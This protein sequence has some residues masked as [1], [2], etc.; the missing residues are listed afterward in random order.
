MGERLQHA[1]S[2]LRSPLGFRVVVLVLAA[3]LVL[4]VAFVPEV[5]RSERSLLT[6]LFELGPWTPVFL[7]LAYSLSAAL[8][9]PAF[10]LDL[11]AGA[12]FDFVLGVFWVQ[13]AA[14]LAAIPGYFIGGR[15]LRRFFDRILEQKPE[16]ARV[17][18]ALAQEGGRIVFLA[19]LSPVFSFSLLSAFFG[20]VG[21]PFRS[22][23]LATSVGILPGTAM[24]VYA[25]AMAGD[26]S[27]SPGNPPRS[28]GQWALDA[29][30]FVATAALVV[31]VTRRAQ[32]VLRKKLDEAESAAPRS[33]A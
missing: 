24:Y 28:S 18:R 7:I 6:R 20:A 10:P 5:R 17:E 1:W 32:R 2:W 19:R 26:L 30:G 14:T 23:L 27:G 4:T 21:V 9:L 13:V 12:H 33:V 15:L 3:A 29:A 16:L 22:Y 8:M 31:Y 11:A 25:G